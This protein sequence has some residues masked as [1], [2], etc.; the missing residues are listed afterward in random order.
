MAKRKQ[1]LNGLYISPR[2]RDS[3]TPIGRCALTTVVAPMGYGKT[4]AIRWYLAEQVK[5]DPAVQTIRVSIYSDNV[6]IFW[7]SVQKAFAFA[8][9]TFLEQYP[10][11][12]D[13]ASASLLVDD[14]CLTLTGPTSY[15]IFIDDFH[16]MTDGRIV[17]FFCILAN[18]LPEN[19]HVIVASRDRFL[20]RGEV[21]RLGGK[22]HQITAEHLRLNHRELATY[23]HRCGIPLQ[24]ADIAALLHSSEGWFSAVYLNLCFL[25]EQGTLPDKQSDIYEMF[26]NALIDPLSPQRQEFL[27]VMGLAD[28]FSAEMARF[29]TEDPE[30]NQTLAALTEQ[31]AFVTRLSDGVTF[32]FHHMMKACAERA[33]AQLDISKQN[34]YRSRYGDWYQAHQQYLYALDA[35]Q[36]CGNYDAALQVIQA[37]AGSCW[38]R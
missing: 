1:N 9:L 5:E 3:L 21:V 11:P 25:A 27:A 20:P 33:F 12:D 23:A 34:A 14:L 28:E 15:Y 24:E 38:L 19:V 7:K 6:P 36:A 35:Y 22:L 26:F 30:T 37:D 31:N 18:R 16:L 32:R 29:I 10:C 2:L 8:G 4:T 13:T 17:D